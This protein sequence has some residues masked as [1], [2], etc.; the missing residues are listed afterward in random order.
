MYPCTFLFK[1]FKP[2]TLD[3]KQNIEQIT[4]VRHCITKTKP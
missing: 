4:G 3:Y 2:M 1:T